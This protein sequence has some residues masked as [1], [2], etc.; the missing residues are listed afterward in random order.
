M[1]FA[2]CA[3]I[4][5]QALGTAP[6]LLQGLLTSPVF[7]YRGCGFFVGAWKGR[8]WRTADMNTLL[9]TGTLEARARSWLRKPPAWSAPAG[10]CP[11]PSNRSCPGDL[12]VIRSGERIP[13]D[14][15][16]RDGASTV[17]GSMLIGAGGFR[18]EAVIVAAVATPLVWWFLGTLELA[19]SHFMSVVATSL[20]LRSFR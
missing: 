1:T 20:R 11:S 18:F 6:A 5:D 17:D 15:V 19:L 9:A 13:V 16:I 7:F 12:V 8:L 2:D 14:G 3:H 10:S 4:V